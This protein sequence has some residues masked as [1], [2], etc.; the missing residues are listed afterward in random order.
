MRALSLWQPWASAIAMG[1]KR[2]ETRGY[3]T[4]FRGPLAICSARTTTGVDVAARGDRAGH[5]MAWR[6]LFFLDNRGLAQIF[7]DLP[8]G[9]VLATC[10]L[11]DCIPA[12]QAK[13]QL[14]QDKDTG[15]G[16]I[17]RQLGDYREGRWAWQLANVQRLEVPVHVY[18]R[19]GLF[20]VHLP[21]TRSAAAA[22]QEG[23]AGGTATSTNAV[24]HAAAEHLQQ[25]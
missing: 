22:P 25:E 24:G 10:D 18:G 5:G 17:E 12:A 9:V 7:R 2:I 4:R 8:R 21:E 19:Q 13:E 6:H 14:L 20:D 23:P 3:R 11:I 1:W 16:W 15:G